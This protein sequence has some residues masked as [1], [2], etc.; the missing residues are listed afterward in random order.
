MSSVIFG[1][2]DPLAPYNCPTNSEQ[3]FVRAVSATKLWERY[4]PKQLHI[5]FQRGKVCDDY[6]FE[7]CKDEFNISA[8]LY[9]PYTSINLVIEH[10]S[11]PPPVPVIT[12]SPASAPAACVVFGL[13][14]RHDIIFGKRKHNIN[15]HSGLV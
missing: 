2:A 12:M 11:L 13:C 15:G 6:Q 14:H 8:L 7:E 9:H 4:R 5:I 10:S 3:C 1:G